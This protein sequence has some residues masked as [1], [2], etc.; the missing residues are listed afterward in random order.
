MAP[1]MCGRCTV[2]WIVC[3]FSRDGQTALVHKTAALYHGRF[4]CLVSRSMELLQ[5]RRDRV[6]RADSIVDKNQALMLSAPNLLPRLMELLRVMNFN[7]SLASFGEGGFSSG[8]GLCRR[9]RLSGGYLL[10]ELAEVAVQHRPFH[11]ES[12]VSAPASCVLGCFGG[13]GK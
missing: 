2:E 9:L 11:Q 10:L 13:I 4:F 1:S 6:V 12:D 7:P 5:L 3:S 8:I